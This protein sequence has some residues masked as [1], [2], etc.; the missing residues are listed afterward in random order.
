MA[1]NDVWRVRIVTKY[2][3]Q[4]GV[5]VVHYRESATTGTGATPQDV[6][7]AVDG[8]VQAAYKAAISTAADYRGVGAARVSPV[9]SLENN[10]VANAGGGSV[11]GGILPTQTAG[12]IS[13][14]TAL[15]GRANRG[16]IYISFPG[17]ADLSVSETPIATYATRIQAISTALIG[18]I[19]AGVGPN[20]STLKL[21]LRHKATG[22]VT[23]V[24]SGLVQLRWATQRRRGDW[25]RQNVLP[26]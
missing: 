11:A 2:A 25:G 19:T 24:V 3:N 10:S 17:S 5:N 1:I 15:P 9:P 7:G 12:L 16:R 21:C 22:T 23:D 14:R 4:I 20:T 18:P 13:W 6:A 26:F 8:A